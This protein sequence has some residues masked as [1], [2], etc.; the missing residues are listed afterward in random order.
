MD[1]DDDNTDYPTNYNH[2]SGQ[3]DENNN[4]AGLFFH[5]CGLSE[6]HDSVEKIIIEDDNYQE[7][8]EY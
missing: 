2:D 5:Y 8:R 4:Q 6:E 3:E 1:E 7:G